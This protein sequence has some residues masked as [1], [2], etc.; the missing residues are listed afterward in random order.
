[1]AT[2]FGTGGF[3]PGFRG[4]TDYDLARPVNEATANYAIVRDKVAGKIAEQLGDAAVPIRK[5]KDKIVNRVNAPMVEAGTLVDG[6]QQ[7]I[8]D[9]LTLQQQE[10]KS[11]VAMLPSSSA[12]PASTDRTITSYPGTIGTVTRNETP[13][14][15]LPPTTPQILGGAGPLVAACSVPIDFPAGFDWSTMHACPA[16]QFPG[17]PPFTIPG[18]EL[19]F[20]DTRAMFAPQVLSFFHW[21]MD[22][23]RQL[24]NIKWNETYFGDPNGQPVYNS[25]QV[26]IDAVCSET[27]A[28]FISYIHSCQTPG[29]PT[30]TN[31]PFPPIPPSPQEPVP[32][33]QP[34]QPQPPQPQPQPQPQPPQPQPQPGEPLLPLCDILR[35]P[36]PGVNS[37]RMYLNFLWTFVPTG[38]NIR[39]QIQP[40]RQPDGTESPPMIVAQAACESC[41]GTF[42]AGAGQAGF[43]EIR[44]GVN[45]PQPPQPPT[46]QPPQ[47]Q[48]QPAGPCNCCCCNHPHTPEQPCPPG[49][50]KRDGVCVLPDSGKKWVAYHSTEKNYCYVVES[51][52][53]KQA[54]SDV[55]VGTG[56]TKES[57]LFAA[58]DICSPANPNP[59]QPEQPLLPKSTDVVC[60]VDS[61]VHL[62]QSETEYDN[63]L[64]QHYVNLES[65]VDKLQFFP[66]DSVQQSGLFDWSERVRKLLNAVV[67][68]VVLPKT[69]ANKWLLNALGVKT[70]L[71]VAAGSVVVLA[72]FL[73]KYVGGPWDY[74][75]T[76]AYYALRRARPM[77]FPSVDDA[78]KAFLGGSIP[79]PVFRSWCEINGYC[80]E[81]QKAMVDAEQSLPGTIELI[82]MY[83]RGMITADQFTQLHRAQGMIQGGLISNLQALSETVPAVSDL[84]RMM[85]R[86]VEDTVI[87]EKFGMDTDFDKKWQ[88]ELKKWSTWQGVGESFMKRVWRAHWSIPSPGQLFAMWHRNGRLP[89]DDPRHVSIDMVKTALEQQDILPFWIPKIL[90]TSYSRLTR[91]DVRRA[92]DIGAIDRERVKE[93]FRELGY[94]EDNAELLTKFTEKSKVKAAMGNRAVRDYVAGINDAVMTEDSLKE[95]GYSP[96]QIAVVMKSARRR[97]F[98]RVRAACLKHLRKR[99]IA[100]ELSEQQAVNSLSDDGYDGHQASEIVGGWKCEAA[101]IGKEFSAAQVLRLM[102]AGVLSAVESSQRL[103]KIGYSVDDAM[104]LITDAANIANIK[105]TKEQER[106]NK[107]QQA[108][109]KK[110]QRELEKTQAKIERDAKA[111]IASVKASQAATLRR[112]KALVNA[113]GSLA[114]CKGISLVDSYAAVRVEYYQLRNTYG[115]TL[116]EAVQAV[117]SAIERCEEEP[118]SDWSATAQ[119]VAK[120]LSEDSSS[121]TAATG[122]TISRVNG[123]IHPS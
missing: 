60:G 119:S 63:E 59:K 122:S 18:R 13:S 110:Q 96:E 76:P 105:F 103:I 21:L 36:Q 111:G 27:N 42:D 67:R 16:P 19:S 22:Y 68:G 57:A 86:D 6:L 115:I 99:F 81:P 71:G 39:W 38:G 94:D 85:V 29:G 41:G 3:D 92:F 10:A 31:D 80:Y 70:T 9:G 74:L 54:D 89:E 77:T 78:R 114:D 5:L 95:D 66:Q 90:A 123:V 49:S 97:F 51:G 12:V 1:M 82:S 79:E 64:K 98:R 102:Q 50:V 44:Q 20:L 35:N 69:S 56:D 61:W 25:W 91:V 17:L 33:P 121:L 28:Y 107:Q 113:A 52:T 15:S 75:I 101:K 14:Q 53:Q 83:R 34:G 93:F 58:S 65:S 112:D 88:G 11:Y 117:V 116:D 106:Q 2:D 55:I 84:T 26:M 73:K 23:A 100:G 120:T 40:A 104:R 48:P 47:P 109:L 4:P 37:P 118:D 62:S 30:N 32:H 87:V 8:R 46:P 24:A 108:E 43:C 7:K 45:P 72:E